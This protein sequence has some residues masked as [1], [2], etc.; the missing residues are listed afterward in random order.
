MAT[1]T[2]ATNRPL[3]SSEWPDEGEREYADLQEQLADE[4]DVDIDSHA[5]ESDAAG[6][7]HYLLA[8]NPD[9][10]PVLLLHGLS[11]TAATWLPMVPVL[12]DEY[13]LVIPDRPGR[14][15][16]NPM[17]YLGRGPRSFFTGYL[18][19]LL[20]ELGIEQPHVVGNSLGGLQA[21]LL[22]VD[23]DCVDKLCIVGAPGGLSTEFPFSYRLITVRGLNR[24]LYWL[25]KQQDSLEYVKENLNNVGVVDDSAVSELFF[26]VFAKNLDLPGRMDSHRTMVTELASF[27]KMNP[28]YDISDEVATIDRPTAFIWGSEDS[29]FEPAVGKPVAD[30]MPNAVFHELEGLGHIP[31]LEPTDEA[32]QLVRE[33]LDG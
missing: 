13:R 6:R 33:F 7:I 8:G 10:E 22:A 25:T 18:V 9:G 17:N 31:F 20:D 24:F 15:L 28:V 32:E 26:R 21:F 5:F 23:H 11:A 12:T 14:G 27:T 3:E 30:R 19:E 4:N 29:F 16:S 2:V 1:K